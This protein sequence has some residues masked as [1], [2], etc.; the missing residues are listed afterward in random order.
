MVATTRLQ[1]SPWP[2]RVKG[3]TTERQLCWRSGCR[4]AFPG[5]RT[6]SFLRDG[7]IVAWCHRRIIDDLGY[8]VDIWKHGEAAA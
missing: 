3:Q 4:A 1:N 5:Y 8:R 6:V 7:R 2:L